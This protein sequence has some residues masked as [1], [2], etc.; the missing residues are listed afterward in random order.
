MDFS[1]LEQNIYDVI[2]EEQIKLGY[3]KEA[4]RLYYPIQSL[5]RFLKADLTISE[6]KTALKNF[7]ETIKDKLGETKVS[8]DGERFCLS[9]SPEAS[10][11]IYLSTEQG[12]F[13][14]DFISTISR[15]NIS[16]EDV[17][18]QFKKYSNKV[19]IEKMTNSEFDY[20][21][22]FE[23]GIPDAFRYCLTDEGGHIIYHRYTIEDYNDF[24]F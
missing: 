22:Y 1:K 23:D 5:N 18:S 13:L 6:M 7:C 21:I 11:Y 3:R 16:I 2:K 19:H 20:L 24:N 9:F 14:Y 8:N 17:I 12:G 15:H 10:E 4:I